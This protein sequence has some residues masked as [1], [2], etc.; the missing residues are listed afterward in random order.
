MELTQEQQRVVLDA[1]SDFG[2]LF[3]IAGDNIN[4]I[5]DTGLASTIINSLYHYETTDI[6]RKAER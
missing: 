2:P 5:S 4:R 3:E 6:E 1:I